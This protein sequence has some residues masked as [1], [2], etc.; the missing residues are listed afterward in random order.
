MHGGGVAGPLYSKWLLK[1]ANFA[2]LPTVWLSAHF[3]NDEDTAIVFEASKGRTTDKKH[4]FVKWGKLV[5][6]GT[7][8]NDG[9]SC[10]HE[11]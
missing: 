1:V 8:L 2:P 7:G 6:V 11:V 10:L 4:M 9:A 5:R 3:V